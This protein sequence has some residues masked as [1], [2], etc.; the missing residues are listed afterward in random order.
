MTMQCEWVWSILRHFVKR[1]KKVGN[2]VTSTF[3]VNTYVILLILIQG[4]RMWDLAFHKVKQAPTIADGERSSDL[5]AG[6][7]FSLSNNEWL[8][9]F[10][11]L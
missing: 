8:W 1:S 11:E 4:L 7:N 5:K 3:L 6:L 10:T 9:E 2:K